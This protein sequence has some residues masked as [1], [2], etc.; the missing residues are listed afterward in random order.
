MMKEADLDSDGQVSFDGMLIRGRWTFSLVHH[1]TSIVGLRWSYALTLKFFSKNHV[2]GTWRLTIPDQ[3][4]IVVWNDFAVITPWFTFNLRNP[5]TGSSVNFNIAT[6][7][8]TIVYSLK[9]LKKWNQFTTFFVILYG[10][11]L[12]MCTYENFA[13]WFWSLFPVPSYM[14]LILG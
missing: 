13:W 14:L 8:A 12:E 2:F 6:P 11:A 1:V 5:H 4:L 3:L 9:V 10:K 7:I